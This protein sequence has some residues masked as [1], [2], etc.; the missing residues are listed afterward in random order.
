MIVTLLLDSWMYTV[1]GIAVLVPSNLPL[2]SSSRK[3]KR[4]GDATLVQFG[5]P[6]TGCSI[7]IDGLSNVARDWTRLDEIG[8][9]V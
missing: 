7:S 5:A 6:E 1:S 9:R 3:R 2:Q 8:R 4:T